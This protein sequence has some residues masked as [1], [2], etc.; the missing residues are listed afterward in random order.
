MTPAHARRCI[1]LLVITLLVATLSGATPALAKPPPPTA[2]PDSYATAVNT[3]LQVDGVI[4]PGVLDNDTGGGGS[5]VAVLDTNVSHGDSVTLNSDGTFNYTPE[6]DFEGT[7]SF[8]Y[9]V[10]IRTLSSAPATVT[11][12]IGSPAAN[13]APVATVSL[14][15]SSPKTNDTLTAT[16][17]R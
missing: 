2:N 15:D 13:T 10:T 1:G 11:I 12:T 17:T 4:R 16:A 9:H 14:N 5:K 3:T 8:T 6:T 7:D